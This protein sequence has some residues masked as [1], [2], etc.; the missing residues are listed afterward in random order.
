VRV[1][2]LLVLLGA[3]TWRPTRWGGE[4][5]LPGGR[6][7]RMPGDEGLRCWCSALYTGCHDTLHV[8]H[9]HHRCLLPSPQ[10]DLA[11][12]AFK[13]QCHEVMRGVGG[14]TPEKAEYLE[15][16]RQQLNLPKET[17]D[18]VIKDVRSEVLGTSSDAMDG[19]WD[20]AKVMKLSGE[21]VDISKALEEPQRRNM[22]RW[23]RAA[24][25]LGSRVEG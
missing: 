3:G 22:F 21:G 8:T 4:W 23:G 19:K 16:M 12:Q 18:K 13:A 17:A 7:G 10:Q 9:H 6:P 5:L 11:E 15:N 1:V 14:V 25:V 24:R 2:V 20:V